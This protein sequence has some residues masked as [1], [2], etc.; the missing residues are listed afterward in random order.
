MNL[1]QVTPVTPNRQS[2][3]VV[4]SG[5]RLSAA[6]YPDEDITDSPCLRC[7]IYFSPHRVILALTLRV[8]QLEDAECAIHSSMGPGKHQHLQSHHFWDTS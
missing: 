6:T 8:H 3:K 2:V 5:A 4:G 7:L 1:D